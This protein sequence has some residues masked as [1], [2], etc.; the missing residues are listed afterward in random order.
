MLKRRI[1]TC[2]AC[3]L[4]AH[5]TRVCPGRGELPCDVL[6]VG[7]APGRTENLTGTAFCGQA[8]KLLDRM[9]KDSGLDQYRLYFTNLVM[10]RPCEGRKEPNRPPLPE[11]ILAC[12][13]NL[14]WTI[15]RARPRVVLLLG[16]VAQ[17]YLRKEFPFAINVVHPSYL[18]RT[19]RESAPGY[20]HALRVIETVHNRI[21]GTDHV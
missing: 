20:L 2:Q 9:V 1:E 11:E 5:R 17:R 19:G 14:Q 10:C 4:A 8:G 13:P 21:G 18:L 15:A 6:V 12:A 16:E 3:R 7:E